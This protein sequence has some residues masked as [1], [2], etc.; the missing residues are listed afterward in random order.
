MSYKASLSRTM[1]SSAFSTS[2]CTERV[3]LYGSTTVSETLGEGNTEKVSIIRS[4]YSSRIFEISKVPIPEPVPPPREWHTWKPAPTQLTCQRTL[5]IHN[6]RTIPLQITF[7]RFLARNTALHLHKRYLVNHS[8]KRTIKVHDIENTKEGQRGKK[9]SI[10]TSIKI[11][12]RRPW[13]LHAYYQTTLK[14]EYINK[15]PYQ[16]NL[17]FL[18]S[19]QEATLHFTYTS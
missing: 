13:H 5:R 1:H 19:L 7:L 14:T 9:T 6:Q 8:Q 16:Y 3:A 12:K 17:H 18:V 11:S 4:G 10:K 15:I 2:W